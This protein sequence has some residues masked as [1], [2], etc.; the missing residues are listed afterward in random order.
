MRSFTFFA[1]LAAAALSLVAAAPV[2]TP[3]IG[4]LNLPAVPRSEQ[5]V[6]A[7]IA[8]VT[9]KVEVAIA[10]LLF[11]T[12]DNCT[13]EF[14]KPVVVEVKDILQVAIHDVTAIT[15]GLVPTA[16][17]VLSGGL[18]VVFSLGGKVL[19]LIDIA[20]LLHTLLLVIFTA[21][22]AVLKVV[23][24]VEKDVIIPLLCEIVALVCDL[25]KIVLSLV[26]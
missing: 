20:K 21:L 5:T 14:I 24:A 15:V 3:K 17:G 26:G 9:V 1:T 7:I 18:A 6:P 10:P 23:G 13:V 22:G 12:K 4:D 11:V 16:T 19:A 8:D 2:E 25:L